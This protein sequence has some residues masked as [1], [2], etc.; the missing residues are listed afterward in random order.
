MPQTIIDLGRRVKAKYPGQYDDLDD[1][2]VGKRVKAR[3]PGDYDDFSDV[4][5]A[6]TAPASGVGDASGNYTRDMPA[7]SIMANQAVNVLEGMGVDPSSPIIGTAKN[8]VGGVKQSYD[9]GAAAVPDIHPTVNQAAR[10]T[11]GALNV[12]KEMAKSILT[13]PARAVMNLMSGNA[14]QA[15]RGAGEFAASVPAVAAAGKVAGQ[16]ARTG[17]VNA[18]VPEKLMARAAV[19]RTP[20]RSGKITVGEALGDAIR[21]VPASATGFAI[22]GTPGAAAGV[23]LNRLRQSQAFRNMKATTQ[24]SIARWLAESEGPSSGVVSSAPEAAPFSIIDEGHGI[25]TNPNSTLIP[26]RYNLTPELD[27]AG[28]ERLT[29]Q[30]RLPAAPY[31]TPEGWTPATA[32]APDV[33]PA[34]A[35]MFTPAPATPRTASARDVMAAAEAI[36]PTARAQRSTMFN[37][38]KLLKEAPDL[39]GLRKGQAFDDALTQNFNRVEKGVIDAE[40]A[41]PRETLVPKR[42]ITGPLKELKAEAAADP[43]L[44]ATV[45]KLDKL[46]TEWDKLPDRIP[47]EQFVTGKRSF[48]DEINPKSAPM[49]R[50]YGV[51]MDAS[52][53]V[54]EA[55]SKANKSYSIVRRAMDDAN[56]ETSSKVNEVTG[57]PHRGTR[58]KQVGKAAKKPNLGASPDRPQPPALPTPAP[59]PVPQTPKAPTARELMRMPA[60]EAMGRLGASVQE[61]EV[62]PFAKF[63]MEDF[64]KSI[65]GG[66]THLVGKLKRPVGVEDMNYEG[67]LEPQRFKG[68]YKKGSV[69]ENFRQP[70]GELAAAIRKGS[71][72]LYEEILE[73]FKPVALDELLRFRQ[74][75]PVSGAA[76][77]R[78]LRAEPER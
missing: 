20:K 43:N 28:L 3:Y 29:K 42:E 34:T 71:G 15:A 65:E 67:R 31:S 37:T 74:Q 24:E 39:I 18:A 17:L 47:W 73:A 51:F 40:A 69:L 41:V 55:L 56:M 45:A 60:K 27:A 76:R 49:F 26:G 36:A 54:S 16:A 48:F 63:L 14:E 72:K 12:G 59:V 52:N 1:A 23:I 66:D 53:K 70:P 46:I 77:Q 5:G 9:A 6:K 7:R 11:V 50:A 62:T 35:P 58:I 2:E 19:N 4:A 75:A 38:P 68:G 78:R 57:L 64:M 33:A 10:T 8:I 22:A 44:G 61:A 13:M 30:G 32:A 25:D 21:D